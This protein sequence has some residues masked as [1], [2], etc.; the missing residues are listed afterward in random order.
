M[1][2]LG[3]QE[4]MDQLAMTNSVHWYGHMSKRED[5]HVLRRGLEVEGQRMKG[6]LRRTWKN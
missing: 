3:L 2:M 1:L 4:T 6:R 5:V